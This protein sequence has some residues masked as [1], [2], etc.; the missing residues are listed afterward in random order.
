MK[1]VIGS[2]HRGV[3]YKALVRQM[4]EAGGHEVQDVGANSDQSAD[5]PDFAQPVARAVADGE[6]DRGVLIC[7]SGIGMS[8][9]ANRFR[10]VRATLC[11][12]ER[13]ARTARAHND[14]NVLCLGQDF[15]DEET[16]RKVVQTWLATPFEAGR[17]ERR[18]CKIDDI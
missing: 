15:V 6:A 13:M 5:Y 9:A 1:I 17:H 10:G 8:I 2:D 12:N 18:I 16:L 11:L 3:R 14:S 7:S 4:L